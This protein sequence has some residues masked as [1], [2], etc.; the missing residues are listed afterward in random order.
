[1]HLLAYLYIQDAKL[2][3]RVFVRHLV[4]DP[5]EHVRQLRRLCLKRPGRGCGEDIAIKSVRDRNCSEYVLLLASQHI[6]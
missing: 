2:S 3:G 4:P 5:R 6:P 1:M